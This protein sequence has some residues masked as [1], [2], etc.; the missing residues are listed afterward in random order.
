MVAP[1]PKR[2]VIQGTSGAQQ[3]KPSGV[4]AADNPIAPGE[5]PCASRMKESSG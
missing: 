2:R 1:A 5:C 3:M 4:I